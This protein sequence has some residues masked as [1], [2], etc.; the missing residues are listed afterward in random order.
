V[1]LPAPPFED[2]RAIC[3]HLVERTATLFLGAGVNAGLLSSE[4]VLCPFAADLSTWLCTDL[5]MS[6]ETHVP[7]DEA[8]EMARHAVGERA[9]NDYLFDKFSKYRP[10]VAHLGLVQLPWDK[11]YTT[12]FDLLLEEAANSGVVQPAGPLRVITSTLADVSVLSEEDI[13]Y[14]KLHGSLDIA[15]THDG[16]LILTKK[17]YREYEKYKKPLFKRLKTDMESRT[18]VFIG[19]SLTD[20]NFRGVLDDCRDELGAQTLPL[21]Y[22]VVHS[23][24]AIQKE[25]WRDRY[26]IELIKADVV[27]FITWLRETW[28]NEN[29]TVVPLLQRRSSEYLRLDT[30]S[31]FQKIGDS[32]YLLRTTD[33]TGK[34]NPKGFFKGAEPTW[35]D[36][37]DQI[38]AR[39][40]LYDP[41]IEGLFPELLD[42]TLDPSAYVITGAAG[43]GKTTLLYSI[44]YDL[45]ADFQAAVLI[46]VPG[47]PL[48]SRLISPLVEPEQPRRFVVVVRFASE[49]FRELAG[50][51]QDVIRQKLPVTLLL[52]DRTNQWHVAKTSYSTKFDPIE[53]TLGSLSSAEISGIIDALASHNCLE[54]LSGLPRSEQL[55]HF[56]ELASE[57][58][59]VALRE[60]TSENSFDQIVRDEYEKIPSEIAKQAYVY[61]AAIGQLDLA[62]R[63]ETIIRVL[64]LSSEQL[65]KELL[66][67]TEGILI[68]GEDTGSSRHNI[69]FRLRARH[70]IIASVIFALAADDDTKKFAVVNGILSELDPGYPED[71]RL[72]RELMKRRELVNTFAEHAMRRALFERL[73][74]ILPGDPYVWQHRSIIERDMQDA[75]QAVRFGRMAA[76]AEPSNLSFANNLGFALEF[77]ARSAEDPLKV[78]ALLSEASKLFEA[79]LSKNSSDPY[80]YLGQINILR[81]RLDREKDRD[82]KKVIFANILSLLVEAYEETHEAPMIAAELARIR[83]QLGSPEE[84]IS[85]VRQA[86]VKKPGEIR[87]RDLLIH[88]LDEREEYS[89]ALLVA[90]EGA[91]LDPTSWKI[92][93]WLGRLRQRGTENVKAVKGAYEAA[94]RH[95]KGDVGLMVEYASYLLKKLQLTEATAQFTALGA[96]SMSAQERRRTRER[97]N[98]PDR[99]AEVFTGKIES[100]AGARGTIVAV[101]ENFRVFFWRTAKGANTQREGDTVKFNVTFSAQGAEA[102]ILNVRVPDKLRVS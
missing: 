19:Y 63:Y 86:L 67:P 102:K 59:L 35:E 69:G 76:K 12:N 75:E 6:P 55:S 99:N 37:R 98:G 82:A 8:T 91:K 72:L 20:T 52:E 31:R 100:F 71:M 28:I 46:H 45:V 53:F 42:I 25:Y 30:S 68:I 74:S 36:V 61:V 33:V 56:N 17:D 79:G 38:P 14:Y 95:H 22:A 47:T 39:R 85:I 94:I 77:A 97:W 49:H 60:L 73:E 5:L 89:E 101:P 1:D 87:L 11:I 18:F 96:L 2:I 92:Q 62:V 64:S 65:A 50:F 40:D 48:D 54:K 41:L 57:D 21:S 26:N 84:G 32:F 81:Q 78:Q 80:N 34:S 90:I 29:C 16:K 3:D 24:S 4:G 58:L 43:T 27:E 83:T 13:P 9:F 44:A 7:L 93:R 51:Y 70:P 66:N 88:F 15:N 23:F 10:G